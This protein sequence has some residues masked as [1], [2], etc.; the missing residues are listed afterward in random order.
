MTVTTFKLSLLGVIGSD[1][2]WDCH[3]TYLLE[4]VVKRMYYINYL[5][6][7]GAPTNNISRVRSSIIRSVLES[8]CTVWHP[9][10]TKQCQ[11]H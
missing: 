5:L 1:L 9:G 3:V 4:E 11:R 8:A 6:R 2:S 7:A 10:L